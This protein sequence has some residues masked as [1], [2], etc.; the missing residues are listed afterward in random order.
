MASSIDATKPEATSATT[1]SVRDNFSA[2]KTEIEA[3]Q[4]TDHAAVTVSG[5]P[6]YITLSGQDIVRAQIDL[7][8]DV[9]GNLPVGNLNSGTSASSATFWRGDG[10]WVTPSGSGDVTK[11][12]TPVN[13]EIGVW[14]GDGT[15]EGDTN[16]T[17]NGTVLAITG[18]IT[19]SSTVDG[20]D[21][22]TDGTK[23]DGIE[24]SATADQSDAEIRTAVEAA[25]DSNVF[26]DADHTK[27]NGIATGADVSVYHTSATVID[28]ANGDSLTFLVPSTAITITGV[29]AH[30]QAGTSILFNVKHGPDPSTPANSLWSSDETVTANTTIDQTFAAFNDATVPADTAI[31]LEITTVTGAVTEFHVTLEYTVD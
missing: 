23:L 9:T 1:Q 14:T 19:I 3:L 25:T 6:D 31:K 27:L 7:A 15:L 24:S 4:G 30:R 11:V 17:W 2:A 16:F 8:A 28:P 5:T 12:G 20:R 29:S 21:I 18:S 22:A 26:T 13:N 10:T